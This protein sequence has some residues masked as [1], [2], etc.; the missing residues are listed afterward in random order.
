MDRTWEVLGSLMG[1]THQAFKSG[2]ML[3]NLEFSLHA[4]GNLGDNTD[5][6]S[7]S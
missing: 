5:L 3:L 1:L 6:L 2:M 4:F 7:N